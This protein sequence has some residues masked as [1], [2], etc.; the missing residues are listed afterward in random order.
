MYLLTV[1]ISSGS[2]IIG[3]V[4]QLQEAVM[5]DKSEYVR[6]RIKVISKDKSPR[7]GMRKQKGRKTGKK[8]TIFVTRRHQNEEEYGERL[9]A[10]TFTA[11]KR[12]LRA[13]GLIP[14]CVTINKKGSTIFIP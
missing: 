14:S 2:L 9:V 1:S 4:N 13:T 6:I 8:A 10:S 11:L 3:E 12:L 7:G 5:T